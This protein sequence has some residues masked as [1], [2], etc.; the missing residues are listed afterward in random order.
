MRTD[1]E[2]GFSFIEV[3][4]SLL[5]ISL[6]GVVLYASFSTG[7]RAIEKAQTEVR[8]AVRHLQADHLIRSAAGAVEIPYWVTDYEMAAGENTL[9]L[10]WY[11]GEKESKTVQLPEGVI[12]EKSELVREDGK[13]PFGIRIQ[14]KIGKREYAAS[15]P[16]ASFPAGK[17]KL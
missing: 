8:T 7:F 4:V 14:Y 3:L 15:A 5:I 10:P 17:V 11:E 13:A 6:V 16:F 2:D 12:I 1:W 9:D